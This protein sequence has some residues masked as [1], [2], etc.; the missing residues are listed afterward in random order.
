M[1]SWERKKEIK[2]KE[3]HSLTCSAKHVCTLC[4]Q[5]ALHKVGKVILY[6]PG[7]DEGLAI[8]KSVLKELGLE[9]DDDTNQADV[10]AGEEPSIIST[11]KKLGWTLMPMTSPVDLQASNLGDLLQHALE[12]VREKF[13]IT[14]EGV[15]FLGMDSP[16]LPLRDIVFGLSASKK[17]DSNDDNNHDSTSTH[18]AVLC[19]ADDGGYGMLCVPSQACPRQTFQGI[20]WSNPLTAVCQI[21]ALTDQDITVSLGRLMHDIDEPEEVKGLCKRLSAMKAS[22]KER[23]DGLVEGGRNTKVA[24]TETK[25]HN[26]LDS[27]CAG[28][29]QTTTTAIVKTG[30]PPCYFTRTVLTELGLLS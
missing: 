8:M 4:L 16:I 14:S 5:A 15:V 26:I 21:K 27:H 17:G 19:P 22:S 18:Q 13:S 24:E 6:A 11:E 28:T 12:R 29:E 3:S 1:I 25:N 2:K 23:N 9:E 20:L 7:N 30:H 10:N